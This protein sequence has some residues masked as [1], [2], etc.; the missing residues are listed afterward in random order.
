MFYLFYVY[1]SPIKIMFQLW[2]LKIGHIENHVQ[3]K[4]STTFLRVVLCT[5]MQ[6]DKASFSSAVMFNMCLFT[7]AEVEINVH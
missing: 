3:N 1:V 2:Q 4:K 5:S 6:V 7:F